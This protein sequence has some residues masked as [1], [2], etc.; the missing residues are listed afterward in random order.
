MFVRVGF[1]PGYPE[2]A[3]RNLSFG[4]HERSRATR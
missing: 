1:R 2:A 3:A 4:R